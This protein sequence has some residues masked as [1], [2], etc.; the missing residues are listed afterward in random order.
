MS[1]IECYKEYGAY[2]RHFNQMQSSCRTLA[3]TW[4]LATLGGIGYVI[5]NINYSP[6]VIDAKTAG[7]LIA[8]AGGTGIFLLWLVDIVVYHRLLVA[9]TIVSDYLEWKMGA[10]RLRSGF[11]DATKSPFL[12]RIFNAVFGARRKM[13]L[14]YLIPL[15]VFLVIAFMLHLSAVRVSSM[16]VPGVIWAWRAWHVLL[17][18]FSLIIFFEDRKEPKDKETHANDKTPTEVA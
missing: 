3:S 12:G 15:L 18:I 9:V 13:S 5:G 2:E 11:K 7:S 6:R 10:P 16:G 17:L 4:L 8:L 14:F 1:D